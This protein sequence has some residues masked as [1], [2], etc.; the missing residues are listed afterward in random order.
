M[1]TLD[2]EEQLYLLS[3]LKHRNIKAFSRFYHEFSPDVFVLAF[4]LLNNED[5]SRKKVDE[6]FSNL[7]E[8]NKFSDI[9]PPIHNYLY[10]EMRKICKIAL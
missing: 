2:F 10:N 1:K 5:Q 6:L 8:E 9:T 3:E 4:N 7:W